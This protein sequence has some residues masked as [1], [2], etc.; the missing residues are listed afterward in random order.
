MKLITYNHDRPILFI[1]IN[2]KKLIN[3]K[4]ILFNLFQTCFFYCLIKRRTE[5][6]QVTFYYSKS[7]LVFYLQNRLLFYYKYMIVIRWKKATMKPIKNII[8]TQII[9]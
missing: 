3:T 2:N 8:K 9:L 7:N 5:N 4:H 6:N 1:N